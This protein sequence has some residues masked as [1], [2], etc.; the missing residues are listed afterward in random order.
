M[1]K[2][3]KLLLAIVDKTRKLLLLVRSNLSLGELEQNPSECR[4]IASLTEEIYVMINDQIFEQQKK[5]SVL[6]S[7]RDKMHK[8][9]TFFDGFEQRKD[10]AYENTLLALFP[11]VLTGVE[12]KIENLLSR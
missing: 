6:V 4:K 8:Y 5:V 2:D 7:A 9:M 10:E 1:E 12:L 3:K 11:A